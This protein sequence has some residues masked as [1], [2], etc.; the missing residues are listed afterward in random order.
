[1]NRSLSSSHL[2]TISVFLRSFFSFFL[3]NIWAFSF[4][5]FLLFV[6][7]YLYSLC[8]SSLSFIIAVSI[9]PH[10]FTFLSFYFYNFSLL[11]QF[12]TFLL[13]SFCFLYFNNSFCFPH[14]GLSFNKSYLFSI[15]FPLAFIFCMFFSMLIYYIYIYISLSLPLSLSV[16]YNTPSLARTMPSRTILRGKLACDAG[17]FAVN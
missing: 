5:I 1:M 10:S 17:D 6:C 12:H 13:H 16:L 7:L 3:S 9:I 11:C 14:L 2:K 15:T 8:T 4:F